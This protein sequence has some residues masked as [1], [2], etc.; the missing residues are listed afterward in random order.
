MEAHADQ[1]V[2]SAQVIHLDGHAEI[3]VAGEFDIAAGTIFQQVVD[4]LLAAGHTE[5]RLNASALRFL[6]AAGIA[7]LLW[8]RQGALCAGGT[9]RI[10]SLRGSPLR[11]L[12]ICEL[13]P[14]LAGDGVRPSVAAPI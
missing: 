5:L 9:L 1:A 12:A 10:D 3:A 13:L 2:F 6:D 8:A 4:D 11:V 14:I 7:C